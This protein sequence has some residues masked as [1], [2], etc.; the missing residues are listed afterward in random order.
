MKNLETYIE[1]LRTFI[2]MKKRKI[3][4]MESKGSEYLSYQKLGMLAA[5]D[6]ILAELDE[7]ESVIDNEE[8]R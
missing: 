4:A 3:M 2:K 6:S 5:Y 7:T 1:Y 8:K